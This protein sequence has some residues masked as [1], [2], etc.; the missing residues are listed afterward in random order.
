MKK[1]CLMF[2]FALLFCNCSKN[3]TGNDLNN[4]ES[5]VLTTAVV[6]TNEGN[7]PIELREGSIIYF[8]EDYLIVKT[9]EKETKL[10]LKDLTNLSY[11]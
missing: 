6:K 8:T 2:I 10:P 5:Q 11:K 1:Q 9:S 3:E 7:T 4:E